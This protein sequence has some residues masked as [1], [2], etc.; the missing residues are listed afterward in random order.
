MVG[1]RYLLLFFTLVLQF[2]VSS[3][4]AHNPITD[5]APKILTSENI[6]PH[7]TAAGQEQAATA[8]WAMK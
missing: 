1:M 8:R 6:P 5:H 3:Y 7:Y 4:N 2:D